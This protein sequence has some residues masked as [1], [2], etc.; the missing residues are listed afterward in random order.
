MTK[1]PVCGMMVDETTTAGHV[2]YLG[3]DYY[4]CSELCQCKFDA[5]PQ[6]YVETLHVAPAV[7]SRS[8]TDIL[9]TCPKHSEV[10]APRSGTCPKCGNPLEPLV[11]EQNTVSP[12]QRG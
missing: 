8:R 7:Q 12:A 10:L 9:Y 6:E 4:F 11:S 3:K 1:D 5:L 2:Q